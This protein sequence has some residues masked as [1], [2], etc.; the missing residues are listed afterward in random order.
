MSAHTW[1]KRTYPRSCVVSGSS[2][3]G[4]ASS[5]HFMQFKSTGSTPYPGDY[6]WMQFTESTES[7]GF[8][9]EAGAE[10]E[11]VMEMDWKTDSSKDFSLVI[12]GTGSQPVLITAE[13]AETQQSTF[14][15]TTPRTSDYNAA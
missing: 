15:Y 4:P 11:V 8:D 14:P 5:A 9:I 13:Y 7:N 10:L 2:Y 6:V 1:A 3:V 12:W